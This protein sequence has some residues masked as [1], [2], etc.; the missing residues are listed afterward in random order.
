MSNIVKFI[1]QSNQSI[2]IYD[3]SLDGDVGDIM[4]WCRFLIMCCRYDLVALST[5]SRAHQ[6]KLGQVPGVQTSTSEADSG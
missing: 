6:V 3:F 2:T 5:T 1:F 4:H